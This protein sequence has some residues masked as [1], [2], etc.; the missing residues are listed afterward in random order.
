MEQFDKIE[1]TRRSVQKILER[2][3]YFSR[4]AQ[5]GNYEALILITDIKQAVKKSNLTER[6]KQIFYYRFLLQCLEEEIAYELNL[7]QNT[8][9]QHIGFIIT[10]VHRRLAGR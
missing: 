9:N 10:K 1:Y 2:F 8:I 5:G 6:Q 3:H 4:L 7:K